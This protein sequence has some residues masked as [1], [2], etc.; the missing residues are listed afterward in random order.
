MY[1]FH[2]VYFVHFMKP[3]VSSQNMGLSI[4]SV[5]LRTWKSY[6][7]EYIL[8]CV[9]GG[10]LR[11]FSVE[12]VLNTW[13]WNWGWV[14]YSVGGGGARCPFLRKCTT[15]DFSIF[16]DNRLLVRHRDTISRISCIW[17]AQSYTISIS[18]ACNSKLILISSICI[19]IFKMFTC[20]ARSLV[21]RAN[22]VGDSLS[23]C[24]TPA[25]L[26]NHS[27]SRSSILT[28]DVVFS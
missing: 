2:F 26:V 1:I 28:H 8:S 17:S 12:D 14:P 13:V 22:N 16:I 7:T 19:T 5:E 27:V 15:A 23:P 4:Y 3:L 24:R 21:K 18:S 11:I 20:L 6:S 10:D 25:E 9:D